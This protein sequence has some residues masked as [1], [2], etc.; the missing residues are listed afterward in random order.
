MTLNT[1]T[2]MTEKQLLMAK[3]YEIFR[4][5]QYDYLLEVFKTCYF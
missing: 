4:N 3:S 2:F 1:F 5:L